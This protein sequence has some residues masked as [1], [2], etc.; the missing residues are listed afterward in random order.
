MSGN[1]NGWIDGDMEVG[2]IVHGL[3]DGEMEWVEHGWVGG[4]E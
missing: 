4:K 3:I 2:W 1:L